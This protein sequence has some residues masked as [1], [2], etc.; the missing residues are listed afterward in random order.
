ML[1]SVPVSSVTIIFLSIVLRRFA[2]RSTAA[3]TI[4][5]NLDPMKKKYKAKDKKW[6][7]KKYVTVPCIR[8]I[9]EKSSTNRFF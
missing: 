4:F 6:G 2:K 8:R 1:I 3:S 5:G 9:S 7:V